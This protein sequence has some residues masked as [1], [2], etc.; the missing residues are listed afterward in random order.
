[1]SIA[2]SSDAIILIYKNKE[3]LEKLKEI[4][5]IFRIKKT[6]IEVN[7]DEDSDKIKERLW[8]SLDLIKVFCKEPGQKPVKKPLV[9]K[10]GSTVQDAAKHLHKD[11]FKY[12]RFARVWG[13]SKYPGEKV[14]LDYELKDGDILEVHIT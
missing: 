8:N 14:G 11:F 9:M 5:S 2:H 1:M 4:L 10:K 7:R 3:E 12:F 13:S 6:F